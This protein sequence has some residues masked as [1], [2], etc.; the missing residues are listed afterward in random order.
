M[1]TWLKRNAG[2]IL[3]TC[4]GTFFT[5]HIGSVSLFMFGEPEFPTED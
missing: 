2:L 5:Y 1:K 3:S 4:L